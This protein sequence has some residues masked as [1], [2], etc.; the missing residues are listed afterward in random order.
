MKTQKQTA[1]FREGLAEL[2]IF[3][4][5]MKFFNKGKIGTWKNYFDDELSAKFDE[6]IEKN[7]KFKHQFNYGN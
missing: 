4:P 7:L 6:A 2:K 1:R 3:K 5:T